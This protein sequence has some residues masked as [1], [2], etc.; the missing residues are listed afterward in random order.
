[1]NTTDATPAELLAVV[2]AHR[3]HRQRRGHGD[4]QITRQVAYRA[5]LQERIA[6]LEAQLRKSEGR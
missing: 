1:M 2:Q 6:E 4:K 5:R 3:S